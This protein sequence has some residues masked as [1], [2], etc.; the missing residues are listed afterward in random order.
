MTTNRIM[1][2][3]ILSPSRFEAEIAAGRIQ[4]RAHPNDPDLRIYSYTKLTQFGGLWTPEARQARGLILQVPNGDFELATVKARGLPKFFTLEQ[5]E[6]D[7]GRAKLVDDDENVVVED[8]PVIPWNLPATVSEKMNGA[9]GLGYIDPEGRFRI[10]T[11]GSFTSLEATVANRV[12]DSKYAEATKKLSEAGTH[13]G[14]PKPYTMLFEII[15]PERPHPVDYGDLEDL[16]YL[17]D[18][19][20][21]TGTWSPA[22]S[23]GWME[24][25]GFTSAKVLNVNSLKEA[26]ELPYE[27][28]T[29]GFVVTVRNAGPDAIYKI[30]PA[31][32]LQLRKLFY[33]LQESELKDFVAADSFLKNL[34]SIKGPQDVDLSALVGDL[35][36]NE[37]MLSLMSKRQETIYSDVVVPANRLISDLQAKLNANFANFTAAYGVSW[38]ETVPRRAVAAWVKSQPKEDQAL[39]FSIYEMLLGGNPL[40]AHKTAVNKVLAVR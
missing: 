17:G 29:E 13:P 36:L 32:Y 31:Q 9:L 1:L 38:V 40:R 27:N 4:E 39:Y 8:A 3:D 35:E 22:T 30:K 12:L 16:I 28:N 26:V 34:D 6:S 18:I 24:K 19:D 23:G 37:Q 10:S 11:K 20:N 5:T 15:T 2:S 25:W 14:F 21:G 7:W 33:A